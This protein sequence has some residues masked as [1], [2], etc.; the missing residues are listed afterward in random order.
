MDAMAA[1]MIGLQ[2]GRHRL[3]AQAVARGLG[4]YDLKRIEVVGDEPDRYVRKWDKPRTWYARANREWRV[5][6][7]PSADGRNWKRHT[8][9]GDMLD[10]A[11]AAGEAPIM[12]RPLP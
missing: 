6:G 1:K 10:L 9:F 2:A 11:A 7:D 5:T 8:S 12:P 4:T 3:P